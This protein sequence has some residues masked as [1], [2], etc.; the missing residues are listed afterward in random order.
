MPS[1]LTRQAGAEREMKITLTQ[2]AVNI[3]LTTL[4]IQVNMIR[5]SRDKFLPEMSRCAESFEVK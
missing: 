5:N 4:I 2:R 1:L 3:R